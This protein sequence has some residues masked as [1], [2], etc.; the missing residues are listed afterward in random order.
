MPMQTLKSVVVP[1]CAL[2]AI[3]AGAVG[4]LLTGVH[5]PARALVGIE[6]EPPAV[7]SKLRAGP[8]QNNQPIHVIEHPI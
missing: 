1:A 5:A 6:S 4:C 7:F 8:Y 3:Y 2:L